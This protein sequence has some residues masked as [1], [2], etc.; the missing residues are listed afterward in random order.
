MTRL[1]P[2]DI[3]NINSELDNYDDQLRYKT[4]ST[5]RG[6]ACHAVGVEE[7]AIQDMIAP[8]KV[9]VISMTCGEGVISGFADTVGQIVAHIG[10]NTFVTRHTD[11][12]GLA[13]AFEKKPDILILADDDRFVAIHIRH[14]RVIDNAVAT[15]QGFAAGLDLMVGGL[16]GKRVLVIG[17]GQVGQNAVTALLNYDARISVYDINQHRCNDFA[18]QLK[19]SLNADIVVENSLK[20][21]LN[22]HRLFIEATNSMNIISENEITPE[23]YI[24]A[25]GIP[26][27]LSPTAYVKVMDR[28]L[29]DPLQIGVATMA[30]SAAIQ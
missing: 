24:A 12:A 18:E 28:L 20:R 6:I 17:C 2:H 1:K 16:T 11:V 10:F 8:V 21:A 3:A 22:E 30:V 5:L 29:H 15:G 4:G 26:L 19:R 13:E 9:G 7:K 25:P 23:T 14:Y 27:G